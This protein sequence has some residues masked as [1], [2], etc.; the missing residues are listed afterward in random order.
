M[1]HTERVHGFTAQENDTGGT[2]A[3]KTIRNACILNG[4]IGLRGRHTI[5]TYGTGD[6][7]AKR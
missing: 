4:H 3:M 7:I 5:R 2:V 6:R 1:V